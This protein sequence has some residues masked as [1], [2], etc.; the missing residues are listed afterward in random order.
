MDFLRLIADDL[1]ALRAETK[2]KYPVVREAVDR[3]AEALPQ[4]Q[5]QYAA[6]LRAGGAAPGPGHA[7][8][9][10]ESVLRPFLLACNHTNAPHKTIILSLVSIQRLVSWDAIEQASVGSIL[11]VLQIQAEKTSHADV[12]VKLLQT[13]LQLVTLGYEEKDAPSHSATAAAA[14][15]SPSRMG[16]SGRS[17]PLSGLTLHRNGS[18]SSAGAAPAAAAAEPENALVGNEDLVMQAIW[19]CLHL[20][21]ASSGANSVVGNTAAMTIRQVVSLAFGKVLKSPEAKRVGVLVFQELCFMGREESGVWLKRTATSPMSAALGVELLETILSS[22]H[23]LFRADPEF[24]G[25]LKQHVCALV[26][27]ALETASVDKH[28]GATGGGGG[29]SSS[30]SSG[31][32]SSGGGGSS[33]GG[34]PFF[35]LLVRVMRLASTVLCHFSDVLGDECAVIVRGL[36]EIV[37]TGA[38]Y[39]PASAKSPSHAK[40]TAQDVK[41]F[42]SSHSS[43]SHGGGGNAGSG[44]GTGS[45]GSAGANSSG[46]FVTWPV[47]LSLEVLNRLCVEAGMVAAL[48]QSPEPVVLSLS[49]TVASVVTTSPP[50]DFK[51]LGTDALVAPRSGLELLNEQDTPALQPFFS[52]IRVAFTCQSNLVASVFELSRA[53]DD[54]AASDALCA[55]C[56]SRIAPFVVHAANCMLRHCREVELVAMALKAYHVLATTASRLRANVQVQPAFADSARRM[57]DVV[58]SCLKALCAFSFPLPDSIKSN[59]KALSGGSGSGSSVSASASLSALSASASADLGD[60]SASDDG[61]SCVVVITWREVHAMKALFAAAHIMEEELTELEW[62][63]LLEG[64]EIVVGLT[65]PKTKSGQ[66]KIPTKHY[67]ISAFRVEDEDVEQ[68]LVMLG[69]SI[70]EFFRDALKLSSRAL[71][72]LLGAVRKVCW[73]QV[74][75]PLPAR[76]DAVAP[77]AEPSGGLSGADLPALPTSHHM[78]IYQNYLGVGLTG[79]GTF[80]PCFALRMLTQLASSS[81]RCFEEVMKELVL[82]STCVSPLQFPQLHQFQVFTTDNILQLMQAA[83]LNVVNSLS[84]TSKAPSQGNLAEV[85]AYVRANPSAPHVFDQEELFLPLAQLVR[86]EMKDRALVGVLDLLNACGHLIHAGWPLV[87]GALEE[88]GEL[89][90]ARTQVSAFKCLRL[91]VDDLLVALPKQFLPHCVRCIGRFARCAKDVNISLTAVNELWSVADLIGKQKSA[92]A[93]ALLE[94]PGGATQRRA[95]QQRDSTLWVC[96]F[97]ELA[98]VALDERSEVRNS[99]INTLFGAAVTYGAQFGLDD[100]QVFIDATVLPLAAKLNDDKSGATAASSSATAVSS[101]GATYAMHHSRDNAEKQWDESRV[102]LLTGISRVL[103]TNWQYLLPHAAWCAAV[104]RQLLAHVA[105]NAA[106]GRAKE[107]ALAA[108]STLQTLL[109][110]SSAG[111]FDQIAQ[112]QPVRAGAG[113]RVVGGALVAAPTTGAGA[114]PSAS[115]KRPSTTPPAP[116]L[117]RDPALWDA[118]FAQLLRLCADRYAGSSGGG[119][120]AGAWKE[121]EEQEIAS[122]VVLVLVTLYAQARE[123][124]LKPVATVTQLLDVLEELLRRHVLRPGA[125]AKAIANITTNSLQSRVLNAFEECGSF[126]AHPAVHAKLLDQL[127]TYVRAAAALRLVFFTRHALTALAKLYASV[128]PEARGERFLEVL[129]CIQPFLKADS[130]EGGAFASEPAVAAATAAAS[131]SKPPSAAQKVAG[132]LWKHALRVLLV[133]VSHGLAAVRLRQACWQPLLATVS[134]F[135]Q[136]GAGTFPVFVRGEEDEVLVLSVLECLVDS[137]LALLGSDRTVKEAAGRQFGDFASELL[138]LLCS[139]VDAPKHNKQFIKCCVRQLATLSIQRGDADL[140]RLAQ[141][142]LV[143]CASTALHGFAALERGAAAAS[144]RSEATGTYSSDSSSSGDE[145]VGARTAARERVVILL[146]SATEV[147]MDPRRVLELFPALCACITSSDVEVRELIQRL[148]VQARVSEFCLDVLDRTE[149]QSLGS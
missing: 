105:R 111:D 125:D 66:N 89:G 108:V 104:W 53:T 145:G 109:Q 144:A 9:K 5:A 26:Q 16:S 60:D 39:Q 143:A 54:A 98:R 32:S 107:V 6:A 149:P 11:R 30:S 116:A 146:A 137:V 22:H 85:E 74:G 113:M 68:Q 34:G 101:S 96:A 130:S 73:D 103:Q 14:A 77:V 121:D 128:S 75:L 52:A 19:I 8:F 51:A 45:G 135:L 58:I 37:A 56:V 139:G 134:L 36:L 131:P 94:G 65:D 38:Y 15:A 132:E 50:V 118:A 59:P 69:N 28:A 12:Q 48:T 3:A 142:K 141:L 138:A 88:A 120:G 110:V 20:H 114:A 100:W 43:N 147:D 148:L 55:A 44:G 115:A 82:M 123:H 40:I 4:L 106:A 119:G 127:V 57:D 25:V 42:L 10:S 27:S 112:S 24:H 97:R 99:A 91:V 87:L 1:K 7:L 81:K 47:L 92:S 126:A 93:R 83:L 140:A 76:E 29:A 41:T 84:P 124:E 102:L 33:S 70:V 67:R 86:S 72:K 80:M 136:P 18:K 122:A 49:R 79:S 21:G 63:A 61:E 71:R 46:S 31:G 62:C 35:P 117:V 95:Q 90:D 17:G 13:L 129:F 133:L 23:R 78:K 64:F 2:K